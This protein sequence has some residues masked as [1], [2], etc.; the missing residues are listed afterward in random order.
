[1]ILEELAFDFRNAIEAAKANNEQGSFLESLL[2]DN[3]VIR[4]ICW[5]S[6]L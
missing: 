2:R 5:L 4:V 1:M 3:A 6:T